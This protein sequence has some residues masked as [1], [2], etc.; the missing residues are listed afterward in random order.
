VEELT[1]DDADDDENIQTREFVLNGVDYLIDD[2]NNVYTVDES[3]DLVGV[4]NPATKT[5]NPVEDD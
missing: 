4:Y 2:D 3:H 5:I 1:V